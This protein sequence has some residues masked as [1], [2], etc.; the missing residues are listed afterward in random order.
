MSS[1]TNFLLA[2]YVARTLG[3]AQFGAFSLAYVT[4]G[5]AINASRGLSIEP[6]LIRFSGAILPTWRRAT[7]RSTGTALLVG[8]VTGTCALAVGRL[9]GGTTGLAFL[10][11]G[12][13]LPGLMLQD[14]WRYSFFAVGRGYQAFIND[15]VWAAFLFPCNGP[16]ADE[17]P[18]ERVLVR[19]RVGRRSPR[20]GRHRTAAGRGYAQP[21]GRDGMAVA[22]P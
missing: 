18:R 8:L 6:L 9:V 11:L 4:Y 1:L 21:G 15:T 5:L 10:A 16:P 20:R 7:A 2:I 3:A 14:S 13:T 12:L 19:P 22:A 17:R